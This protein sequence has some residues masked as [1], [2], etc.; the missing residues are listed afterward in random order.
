MATLESK[1]AAAKKL[2]REHLSSVGVDWQPVTEDV[3]KKL[4]EM[5]ATSTETLEEVSEGDLVSVGVPPLVARRVVK[6]FGGAATT[7]QPKQI[8][9]IDDDPEKLARRLKPADLVAEY[10]PNEPDNAFGDRLQQI[11]NG[12]R[13]LVFDDEGV[14]DVKTSA[15]ILQDLRDNYTERN[16]VIVNGST[17]QT[18]RVGERP[19]R[20]G[21]EHPLYPGEL[22]Y[23]DGYSK[24]NVEWGKVEF[25]V[26]QLLYLAVQAKEILMD[27][28]REREIFDLVQGKTFGEV[29]EHFVDAAIKFKELESGEQLPPLKISLTSRKE[30]AKG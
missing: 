1:V 28:E 13:F 27:R 14:L 11:A 30:A 10:D 24:K 21:D 18:Y 16:S 19:S 9:L 5:G 22:L 7:D 26:R 17:R 29:C 15:R 8:V 25:C 2:L 20:F 23:S 12:R 4:Q 6:I 3:V